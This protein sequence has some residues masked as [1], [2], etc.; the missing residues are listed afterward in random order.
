MA[1]LRLARKRGQGGCQ[2]IRGEEG[3]GFEGTCN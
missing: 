3:I 1:F 2:D